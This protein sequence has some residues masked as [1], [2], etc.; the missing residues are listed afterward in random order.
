V[1]AIVP[2]EVVGEKLLALSLLTTILFCVL[3]RRGKYRIPAANSSLA[4][5]IYDQALADRVYCLYE[6]FRRVRLGG[7]RTVRM[8]EMPVSRINIVTKSS[9]IVR[10]ANVSR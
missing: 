10:K 7:C 3:L 6:R 8:A 9:Q 2:N 1:G 5:D 4:G